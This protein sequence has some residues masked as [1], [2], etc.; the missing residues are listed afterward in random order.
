VP[1]HDLGK[2]GCLME[3]T[4]REKGA[5]IWAPVLSLFVSVLLLISLTG[6]ACVHGSS[7]V[8]PVAPDQSRGGGNGGG[9]GY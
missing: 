6:A 2:K 7:M 9:G 3:Y 1:A 5:D 8:P 4:R